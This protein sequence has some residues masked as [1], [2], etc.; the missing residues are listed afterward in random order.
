MVHKHHIECPLVVDH[1]ERVPI[2]QV[3][4]VLV[5]EAYRGETLLSRSLLDPLSKPYRVLAVVNSFEILVALL[6][7]LE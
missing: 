7:Q 5:F 1:I 6:G 3:E 4:S 2:Q